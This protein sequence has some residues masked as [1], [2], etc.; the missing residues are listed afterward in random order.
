MTDQINPDDNLVAAMNHVADHVDPTVGSSTG[1]EP[2]NPA[3]AQV[4]V[5]TTHEDRE[6]WKQAAEARGLSLSDF[7]RR[8][9]AVAVAEVLDCPHPLQQRRW[10]PWA[11]FCL[12]CGNR[13]RG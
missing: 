6:R 9:I 2:G 12:A 1:A 5:R 8:V 10:Y 11:E 4:L 3:T 13:L 7:L